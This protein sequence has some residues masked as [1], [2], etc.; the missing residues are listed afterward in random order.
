MAFSFRPYPNC[1]L[2]ILLL[3]L[4]LLLPPSSQASSSPLP[5]STLLTKL[6]RILPSQ[7]STK[8]G[9]SLGL[10][11]VLP[12]L[13]I[14]A[15]SLLLPFP[16][17][18]AISL[19]SHRLPTLLPTTLPLTVK[20]LLS[21][22]S[23]AASLFPLKDATIDTAIHQ[24]PHTLSYTATIPLPTLDLLLPTFTPTLSSPNSPYTHALTLSH[25]PSQTTVSY[26]PSPKTVT[27][28]A[29]IPP[30]KYSYSRRFAPP[31]LPSPPSFTYTPSPSFTSPSTLSLTSPPLKPLNSPQLTLKVTHTGSDIDKV[32]LAVR[33]SG[34]EAECQLYL[35]SL[36]HN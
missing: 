7:T 2:S 8:I 1:S 27:V 22:R 25:D 19:T 24:P 29:A 14:D 34:V 20:L 23:L 35:N 28:T 4:F 33:A 26:S 9:E 17:Q 10:E 36:N 15:H 6:S 30:F 11:D 16:Q 21:P 13:S 32:T 5:N 31:L 18:I 12:P 3:L